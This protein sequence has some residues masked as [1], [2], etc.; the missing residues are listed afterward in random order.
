MHPG[1]EKPLEM[2]TATGTYEAQ[3][4]DLQE[5]YPQGF[6][7]LFG[8]GLR[9]E[10]HTEE[11]LQAIAGRKRAV[12][13][14]QT[15]FEAENIVFFNTDAADELFGSHDWSVIPYRLAL[16]IIHAREQ[17]ETR[18]PEINR[19]RKRE[20][21]RL[22]RIKKEAEG[23]RGKLQT[24]HR[25]GEIPYFF[26]YYYVPIRIGAIEDYYQEIRTLANDFKK[27]FYAHRVAEL[28][29]SYLGRIFSSDELKTFTFV[30]VPA[31]D[32]ESTKMRFREFSRLVC[33]ATGMKN[34]FNGIASQE[35]GFE[36]HY[37]N[38]DRQLTVDLRNKYFR[39][40]K[41]V[42]FDDIVTSGET[43]R[44]YTDLLEKNKASV[45]FCMS[46]CKTDAWPGGHP[47]LNIQNK[48]E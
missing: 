6:Q 28:V 39:G 43:I 21:S 18:Q 41:V 34:G 30:C 36:K 42:V 19:A 9:P 20:R 45:V 26:F 11:E 23:I 40:R 2:R 31:H 3:V 1:A 32:S 38:D 4:R 29:S 22:D 13:N 48:D 5:K 14:A 35:D 44:S 7:R 12:M 10:S 24:G 37:G 27:G 33:S 8:Y 17:L 15:I 46:L 16:D 25:I 47:W